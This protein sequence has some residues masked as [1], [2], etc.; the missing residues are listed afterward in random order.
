M[1]PFVPL[2][3]LLAGCGTKHGLTI[4]DK[5]SA[6]VGRKCTLRPEWMA[7]VTSASMPRTHTALRS[8]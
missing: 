2:L 1:K 3:L 6:S 4:R 8:T 7:E 5:F